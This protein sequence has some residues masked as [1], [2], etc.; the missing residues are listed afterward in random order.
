M[1]AF[2]TTTLTS[3]T[4]QSQ[5]YVAPSNATGGNSWMSIKDGST[6]Y[7]VQNV[8][9]P[10]NTNEIVGVG[11]AVYGS[12]NGSTTVFH[13]VYKHTDG[14]NAVTW[15]LFSA[16]VNTNNYY[17]PNTLYATSVSGLSRPGFMENLV[18]IDLDGVNGIGPTGL[19]IASQTVNNTTIAD[20]GDHVLAKDSQ[21]YF[22]FLEKTNGTDS[23][24]SA[25]AVKGGSIWYEPLIAKDS[26]GN[27]LRTDELENDNGSGYSNKP[28]AVV[29]SNTAPPSEYNA[30]MSSG[31]SPAGYYVAVKYL[32]GANSKPQW[33]IRKFNISGERDYSYNS[34]RSE[35]ISQFEEFFGQDLNGDGVTLNTPLPTAITT[36]NYSDG[37]VAG[38]NIDGDVFIKDGTSQDTP[39]K[40]IKSSM[41]SYA[42]ESSD[43][44]SKSE[45][46]AATKAGQTTGTYLLAVKN[47]K[48]MTSNTPTTDWDVFT[49][50]TKAAYLLANTSS[51][52]TTTT[53]SGSYTPPAATTGATLSSN[54][55]DNDL[56]ISNYGSNDVVRGASIGDYES[57]FGQDLNG[58][59]TTGLNKANIRG[60]ATDT[61]GVRL[62]RDIN[63]KSLF[64]AE[65]TGNTRTLKAITST[66]AIE[67]NNSNTGWG[68]KSEAVAVEAIRDNTNDI[69]GYK[70]ALKR[71]EFNNYNMGASAG[72]ALAGGGTETAPKITWDIL[73]L[74]EDGKLLNGYY[75]SATR[76]WKD[77]AVRN[78]PSI[79]PYEAFFG[80]DL[81][82]DGKAGIDAAS[83]AMSTLDKSGVK[84]GRDADKSLYIV[85]G[86]SVKAVGNASWLEYANSWT[87]GNN[88]TNSNETKA[89]AVEAIRDSNN[90]IT[91]YKLALK[92]TNSYDGN[93]TVA[94]DILKLDADAK[95]TYSYYD[96]ATQMWKDDSLRGQ[97]SIAPFEEFFGDDLNED[98]RTG[99]DVASLT[100]A[101][102]DTNGI[103]LARDKENSLYLLDGN[104]AKAI[105]ASWLEYSNSWGNGSNK[106]EAIAAEAV[107]NSSGTIT[108]YKLALK[109]TDVYDG[110]TTINWDVV[111]LTAEA[112]LENASGAA[113][114]GGSSQT[115]SISAFEDLF[116]QDLNGD[117]RIGIDTASLVKVSTDTTG[118]YLARDAEK[119][120][121]IVNGNSAKAVG[122][123][124]WLE[125]DNNWGSG[126]NKREAIAVEAVKD[127]N[128]NIT[129]YKLAMK[130]TNNWNGT[131]NTTWDVLHLDSDAKITYGRWSDTENKWVDNSVY[132][133]KS[134]VAYET[135]FD[136]DLN[137]DGKIGIDVATL[138]M[139]TTDTR[140]VR[141]ARDKDNALFIVDGAGAAA[142]AKA[143]G[144][145]S[146]LEYN[147][148]WG[149]GSNKMEAMAVEATLDVSNNI[150]GYKLALKQTNDWNGNKDENWQVLNLD[151]QG[152][153]NWGGTAGGAL[154]TKKIRQVE[155][156]VKE[157]LNNDGTVGISTTS[158][159]TFTEAR[160]TGADD[161]V[162]LAQDSNDKAFYIMDDSTA[163]TLIDTF[164][165]TPE[166]AYT[167][168]WGS[169]SSTAE[170]MGVAKQTVGNDYQFRIAVKVTNTFGSTSDVSWQIHTV[171]KEGVLDWS[172]VATARS[173]G[174]F[175]SIF[176]QDLDGVTNATP[177][178]IATDTGTVKLLKD[179][180]GVLYIQD[181]GETD[182]NGMTFLV[183]AQGGSPSFDFDTGSLKS[184][185]YAIHKLSD[186][187]YRLAVKKTSS[188]QTVKWEVYNV[189][190]RNASTDEAAINRSKTVFLKDVRDVEALINQDIN[191]DGTVGRPAETTNVANDD[192]L[193]KAALT[194]Q[195]QLYINNNGT[196]IAVVDSFGLGVILNKSETWDSGASSFLAEVVSAEKVDTT[197]GNTTTRTYKIAVRETTTLK[198]Q[199]P[200]INWKIYTTDSTGLLTAKPV[201]TKSISR[202]ETVFNQN[203]TPNVGASLGVDQASLTPLNG[204]SDVALDATGAVYVRNSGTLIQ[205]TDG[206]DGAISFESSETLPDGFSTSKV[207]GAQTQ[208]NGN[209]LLAVE[210]ASSV[211]DVSDK[212]WVVHTLTVQ[213][214]GA[215]AYASIDWTK[216]VVTDDMTDYSALFGQTF[217]QD[218]ATLGA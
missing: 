49:I 104:N 1:A 130:Q 199:E 192:G 206:L 62:E 120:L 41:G 194:A 178:A 43:S 170:V 169:G 167:R 136:Q 125:Y 133:V 146:W 181:T 39:F 134:M 13:V 212:S 95:V 183:D 19:T 54:I 186:N 103:L 184:E 26:G 74:D 176:G 56:I 126:S 24:H 203:L 171:S 84:L 109:Q 114:A 60:M 11:K 179:E 87:N 32:N 93:T 165:S 160:I 66:Y 10:S 22:Y 105:S 3:D 144:N 61:L 69:T 135:L 42:I 148:S 155:N 214:T 145:A 90:T 159:T 36:D 53:G 28:V 35:K 50:R 59:G 108:G 166:L 202:W 213:G 81:N 112:R 139:A 37:V 4:T 33:E 154:W 94:W 116:N 177:T 119:A 211:G 25:T 46:I 131:D 190:V 51:T 185:T 20:S 18:G 16:K 127:G 98:G 115:K 168:Q 217:T 156:L 73:L 92:Q 204:D 101:S 72:T 58:D 15:D 34:N 153:V 151:A 65:G 210:Y 188:N 198:D 138:K 216:A 195:N 209:I 79:S 5:H 52:T 9:A 31:Q 86:N 123:S 8:P 111:T 57:K 162:K 200:S 102:T 40:I 172:K 173:P 6:T 189:G 174:R 100:K 83:L 152:N 2:V 215:T 207:V 63:D 29:Y 107:R 45:V 196:K 78:A 89:V 85:N 113:M 88:V 70:L 121:Y 30:P 180:A 197:S 128:G 64:I 205:V 38:R 67:Y 143:V 118:L 106:K 141:L 47:T 91:G 97:K 96:S 150:T 75:D 147:N 157:D 27:F 122:N 44:N 14:N 163:I 71:T 124:S 132:G 191:S 129:A 82:G 182:N 23:Q 201:E 48:A 110:K 76:M 80:E 117:G 77:D 142:V 187:T 158:L 161:K 21:G 17:D 218:V 175:E 208:D 12:G 140:G 68:S 7:K 137:N 193:V 55:G 99:V 149:G 164:G